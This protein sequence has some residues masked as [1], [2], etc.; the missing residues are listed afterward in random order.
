[1]SILVEAHDAVRVLRFNRPDARNAMSTTMLEE[2]LEAM[3]DAAA[4]DAVAAVVLTGA[5]GAFS[6]GADLREELDHQGSVR[7]MDLLCHVYE[8]VAT[9]PKPTVAA[10][11]GHCVGGGIEVAAA[12]D[13]RVADPTASFRFPGATLGIAVGAAKLVGLVGLGTAKDLVLTSRTFSAEEGWRLGFVQRLAQPGQALAVALEVAGEITAN[14]PHAVAFLRRQFLAFTGMADRV[15]AEND[16]LHALAEAAGDYGA[17]T[18]ANPVT[19]RTPG[20]GTHR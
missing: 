8:G 13:I 20:M 14:N 16:V 5:G 19:G 7:R 15:A 18:H 6:A 11:E 17:V 2:L 10:V 3:A 9:F 4:D 1:M 12:V